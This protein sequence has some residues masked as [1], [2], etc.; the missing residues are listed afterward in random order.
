MFF[1][2]FSSNY[3][4]LIDFVTHNYKDDKIDCHNI[5]IQF[6]EMYLI[7]YLFYLISD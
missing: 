6:I 7:F 5:Y 3:L 2:E 4:Q 1:I